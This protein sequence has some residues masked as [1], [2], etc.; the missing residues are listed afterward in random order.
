MIGRAGE[1]VIAIAKEAGIGKKWRTM[2][3]IEQ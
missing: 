3:G 1:R 2:G